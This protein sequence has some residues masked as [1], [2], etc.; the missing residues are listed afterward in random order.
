MNIFLLWCSYVEWFSE[1]S[2]TFFV[3]YIMCFLLQRIITSLNYT[4]VGMLLGHK[5]ACILG[6]QP[7]E[8]LI[9]LLSYREYPESQ[10]KD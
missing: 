5:K 1:I 9:N 2:L 10:E 8:I 7:G 3:E 6:L 4:G